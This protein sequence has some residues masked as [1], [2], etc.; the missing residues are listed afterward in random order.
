M[1]RRE[2]FS[3]SVNILRLSVFSTVLAVLTLTVIDQLTGDP[4][5]VDGIAGEIVL[6]DQTKK[7]VTT[8]MWRWNGVFNLACSLN[9]WDRT[10]VIQYRDVPVTL[11]TKAV[12]DLESSML[13]KVDTDQNGIT[14]FT[15]SPISM[16]LS[17]SNPIQPLQRGTDMIYELLL[18]N[19][20]DPSTFSINVEVPPAWSYTLSETTVMLNAGE[21]VTVLLTVTSPAE[22][23]EQDYDIHVDAFCVEDF[24]LT[25]SMDLI[26][27][28]SSELA[29]EDVLVLGNQE[30]V[31]LTSVVS[32][33]G[34]VDAAMVT[35]YFYCGLPCGGKLL[36]EQLV[37][38]P[39]GE[40]AFV[41]LGCS[42]SEG[43]YTF[44]VIVDPANVI[45]ESCEFNN[46]LKI[47]YLLDHTPPECEISFDPKSQNLVIKGI[48]NLDC[49]VDLC[50]IESKQKGKA[51]QVYT[52]IDDTKNTTEITFEITQN[53]HHFE[54]EITGLK[55]NGE[56]AALPSNSL[57]IEYIVENNSIKILNQYL[58]IEKSKV[59]L[60]YNGNKDETRVIMNGTS[61]E[62][63]GCLLLVIR[64]DRGDLLKTIGNLE[65]VS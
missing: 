36:G 44:S 21:S 55:Y 25:T 51:I 33:M 41:S 23:L 12:L 32:N 4:I 10:T 40:T 34:L 53:N 42:L 48:D 22:L 29:V 30:D 49:A 31:M 8:D 56:P 1:R 17:S 64:T 18:K 19:K 13:L 2:V 16:E 35:I 3:I 46:E 50:I 65:W 7:T 52:L 57:K 6:P 37:A 9:L 63:E 43:F 5:R 39:S 60:I 20:G 59:H 62:E 11:N 27:S 26:A 54:S 58:T 38:V 28:F 45:P 15:V 61:V 24:T 14:D 47:T